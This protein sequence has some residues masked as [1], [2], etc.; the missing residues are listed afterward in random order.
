MPSISASDRTPF[1]SLAFCEADLMWSLMSSSPCSS[2]ARS[3]NLLTPSSVRLRNSSSSSARPSRHATTVAAL[4][5]EGFFHRRRWLLVIIPDDRRPI[6]KRVEGGSAL[7]GPVGIAA[8]AIDEGDP[9]GRNGV[10]A[11]RCPVLVETTDKADLAGALADDHRFGRERRRDTSGS[12]SGC[13][14]RC[15]RVSTSCLSTAGAS[16]TTGCPTARAERRANASS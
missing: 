16:R 7:E 12:C 14:P 3:I 10:V 2:T 8:A 9:V 13:R 4:G 11:V 1:R 5:D 6:S 15:R